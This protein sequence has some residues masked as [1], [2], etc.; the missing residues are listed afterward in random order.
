[1][2]QDGTDLL[3]PLFVGGG[4]EKDREDVSEDDFSEE[5]ASDENSDDEDIFLMRAATMESLSV[6]YKTM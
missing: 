3:A 2:L 6:E 4:S 1:M 5:S